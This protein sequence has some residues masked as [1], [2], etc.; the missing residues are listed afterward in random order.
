MGGVRFPQHLLYVR[1]DF[2]ITKCVC[3]SPS[4]APP[5]PNPCPINPL[6]PHNVQCSFKQMMTSAE[7]LRIIKEALA[8]A[9]EYYLGQL[10]SLYGTFVPQ[11]IP[12]F[13]SDALGGR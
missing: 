2:T 8:E 3:C 4:F 9:R 5:P 11:Y 12:T 6:T 10:D 13:Y 1:G 7:R